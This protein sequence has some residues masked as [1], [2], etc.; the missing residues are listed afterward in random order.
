MHM[1][2]TW[3]KILLL[4]VDEKIASSLYFMFDT[5][6]SLIIK[7]S[8]VLFSCLHRK[9]AKHVSFDEHYCVTSLGSLMFLLP[10]I[11]FCIP[12]GIFSIFFTSKWLLL[13]RHARLNF[14][15]QC[16]NLSCVILAVERKMFESLEEI[17]EVVK[18]HT[19]QLN[20]IL[21]KLDSSKET[22]EAATREC[23]PTFVNLPRRP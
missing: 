15:L 10:T 12:F 16:H 4:L 9:N 6:V 21:K 11:F 8:S 20:T 18:L 14:N 17:K 2:S 22:S 1:N 13:L 5:G 3:L 7:L 19:T 23:L